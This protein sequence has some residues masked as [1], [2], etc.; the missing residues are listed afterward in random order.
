MMRAWDHNGDNKLSKAEFMKNMESFVSDHENWEH[1]VAQ[2]AAEAFSRLDSD[3]NGTVDMT[4]LS[5]WIEGPKKPNATFVRRKLARKS[6]M[7]VALRK[8]PTTAVPAAAV[9]PKE[10]K[11]YHY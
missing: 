9:I 11:K 4:E 1:H 5:R 2:V 3:G 10:K 7:V 6:S 8:G